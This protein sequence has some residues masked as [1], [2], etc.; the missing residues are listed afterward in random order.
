MKKILILQPGGLGDIIFVMA[1]AQQ[2]V[3]DGYVVDFPLYNTH[4]EN[5][6]LQK[7]FPEVNLISMD[8]FTLTKFEHYNQ[9]KYALAIDL[10]EDDTY[11]T[12]PVGGSPLRSKQ[13][14]QH[15]KNKYDF[16]NLKLDLWRDIKIKRDFSSEKKLMKKLGIESGSEYNLIN[17]NHHHRFNK[18]NIPVNPNENNIYMSKMDGFSLFDWIGVMVNAKSIHTVGSSI[19]FLLELYDMSNDIHIYRR[20]DKPHSTYD[21]LLKKPYN[22]H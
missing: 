10:Y 15:M 14:T 3:K 4:L 16:L 18:I 7:Y 22:Y 1:I 13:A 9:K 12:I 21:Y 19:V 8:N 20:A 6:S 11:L 2:Y 5:P 17:E